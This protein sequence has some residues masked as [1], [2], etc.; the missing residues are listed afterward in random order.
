[1]FNGSV[2]WISREGE[3]SKRISYMK[4]RLRPHYRLVFACMLLLV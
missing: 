3:V 2:V 4:L 1:M